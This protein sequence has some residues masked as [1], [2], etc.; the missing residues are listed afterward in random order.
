MKI[1]NVV[2]VMGVFLGLAT[3]FVPIASSASNRVAATTGAAGFFVAQNGVALSKFPSRSRLSAAVV[4]GTTVPVTT[5]G[6]WQAGS[7]AAWLSVTPLGTTGQQL[8]LTANPTGLIPDSLY[9]ATVAVKA[10]SGST[11]TGTTSIRV[12]LW[13]GSSDPVDQIIEHEAVSMSANPVE[14]WVYVSDGSSDIDVYNVYDGQLV[15]SFAGVAPTVGELQVSSDGTQLFAVDTTNYRIL[16]LN[17]KSGRALKGYRLTGPISSDFSFAYARPVG[18]P[19]L[20]APGQPAIDV[21]TGN[22]VSLPFQGA[23]SYDPFIVSTADGSHLAVLE[24]GLSPGSVY[25]YEVA[26][27]DGQLTL[28][29]IAAARLNGSNCQDMAISPSGSRLYPACG[30]P[31]QFDVYDFDSGAKVQTLAA[32]NYPNNA[33]FDSYGEFVGG[34]DGT[35]ADADVYVYNIRGYNLGTVPLIEYA[36]S[37]TNRVMK[38]SGDSTRVISGTWNPD[39]QILFR[40]MPSH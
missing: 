40:Q 24:R 7:N 2:S 16:A 15:N 14:P 34:I 10:R 36:Q 29:S 38:I 18:I 21:S 28:T 5:P 35:Y 39:D 31:Y 3:A 19:T 25:S 1:R 12:A 26:S 20:F 8:R 33:E 4:V 32:T 23:F 37:Q 30:A 17:A 11:V 9:T 27:N 13:I 22:H 6:R